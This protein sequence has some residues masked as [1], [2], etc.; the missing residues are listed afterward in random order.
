ML[1][2]PRQHVRHRLRVPLASGRRHTARIEGLSNL[3]KCPRA[4]LL[5][6]KDD[7]KHVRGVLIRLSVPNQ[8]LQQSNADRFSY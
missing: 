8:T 5:H 2:S 1:L 6:L 7:G 3:P 4:S